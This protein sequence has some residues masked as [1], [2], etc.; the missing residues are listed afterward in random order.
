LARSGHL[1]VRQYRIIGQQKDTAMDTDPTAAPP[2]APAAASLTRRVLAWFIDYLVV[3][4]PGATVVGLALMS[5]VHGLPAYFGAVGGQVGWSHLLKLFTQHGSE[6]ARLGTAAAHEWIPYVFPILGAL[7]L[8]PM[9]QCGY[10]TIC[11]VWRGRTFGKFVTDTRVGV[12]SAGASRVHG[13]R[14]FRRALTTTV[15]ETGLVSTAFIVVAIGQFRIGMLIWAVAVAAFWLNAFAALGRRHR[16]IV[17]RISGTTV[18][19]TAMYAKVAD[20]TAEIAVAA[21]RKTADLAIA[22]KDKTADFAVAAKEKTADLAIAAKDK[23]ADFTVAAK[24]KTADFAI[25]AKEKTADF[26]IAAKDKTGDLAVAAKN[27]T[28]AAAVK[29]SQVG[30]DAASVVSELALSGMKAV[31]DTK[32]VKQALSSDAVVQAKQLGEAGVGQAK[33][34]GE[35][36]VGQARKLGEAGIGQARKLGEAGVVQARNLGGQTADKVKGLGGMFTDR[37]KQRQAN[38]LPSVRISALDPRELP[39]DEPLRPDE[40]GVGGEPGEALGEPWTPDGPGMGAG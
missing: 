19:R 27:K 34:L 7:A 37:L 26:A 23:T 15:L 33:Q 11:L 22:A 17:D 9:L 3:M 20:T 40:G 13:R 21:T 16:T 30:A 4:V 35:A 38:R 32:A 25:A 36:G 29:A 10:H 12:T 5:L 6:L 8:V 28:A 39:Q 31:A 24:D 14:A 18:V 2:M 1:P